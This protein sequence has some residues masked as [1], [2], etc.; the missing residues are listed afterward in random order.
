MFY[1]HQF[2]S[3]GTVRRSKGIT[4]RVES[5]DPNDPWT[6]T[7]KLTKRREVSSSALKNE[8]SAPVRFGVLACSMQL[9]RFPAP[10]EDDFKVS[11]P[12]D[13]TRTNTLIEA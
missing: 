6:D 2:T 9:T 7:L 12:N 3:F 8:S 1:G 11:V 4:V 10:K 5:T 13:F